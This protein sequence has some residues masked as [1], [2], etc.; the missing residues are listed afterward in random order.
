[1]TN[2]SE[3]EELSAEIF[4]ISAD[5]QNFDYGLNTEL[6]TKSDRL[7]FIDPTVADYQTLIDNLSQP[8]EVVILDAELDGIAQITDSLS[9][10]DDL[11]AVHIVSHGDVGKLFLGSTVLERD[12]LSEYADELGSW[13]DS[14]TEAG[15][16]LL[17]GCD[18]ASNLAGV[19]FVKDLSQ[20]TNADI[21]ASDDLTGSSELDGDWYL[22]YATG[23]IEAEIIFDNLVFEIY[24]NIFNEFPVFDNGTY[25]ED[26]TDV[27]TLPGSS[28]RNS[29]SLIKID[30]FFDSPDL[31]EFAP[32][33]FGTEFS[34][35]DFRVDY[36]P[37][38]LNF[39]NPPND[40]DVSII[41]FPQAENQ[42]FSLNF[43]QGNYNLPYYVPDDYD[44][45][46]PITNNLIFN[47][48]ASSLNFNAVNFE[49]T[50]ISANEFGTIDSAHD[51]ITFKF[52]AGTLDFSSL[53]DRSSLS[54]ELNPGSFD[55]YD[56]QYDNI[57]RISD[58]FLFDATAVTFR[59]DSITF[60]YKPD[61]FY[62][63]PGLFAA[64]ANLYE[65]KLSAADFN[66]GVSFEQF[67]ASD[68]RALDY[69]FEG[70]E[71]F[72]SNHYLNQG[73]TPNGMN[74]FTDYVENG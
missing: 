10:Y 35:S 71:L 30:K 64:N 34:G 12:T 63:N 1:M 65:Y 50:S 25:F 46:E 7:L 52:D 73:V 2:N 15:D 44:Y 17:Y 72:D 68:Y 49:F 24:D 4:H 26:L 3:L 29:P 32:I 55:F 8:A 51:S 56:I 6:L 57:V 5:N 31:V 19:E 22:E 41:D 13:G 23:E 14:L 40:P 38:N 36:V 18:V 70:D 62:F 27:I 9:N 58:N 33:N 39:T 20:Y 60:D 74:L 45:E 66:A 54:F 21:L 11:D 42:P 53:T 59:S 67:N 47:F 48:D 43:G 37:I 16:I 61:T 28:T 69:A